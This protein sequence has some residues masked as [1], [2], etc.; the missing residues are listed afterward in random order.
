MTAAGAGP[1]RPA[2][3]KKI[4]PRATEP[5]TPSPSWGNGFGRPARASAKGTSAASPATCVCAAACTRSAVLSLEPCPENGNRAV[6]S[7]DPSPENGNPVSPAFHSEQDVSHQSH[8]RD[9][10]GVG[11]RGAAAWATMPVSGAASSVTTSGCEG[12]GV[13]DGRLG[14][15]GEDENVVLARVVTS[16]CKPSGGLEHLQALAAFGGKA[17]ERGEGPDAAETARGLRRLEELD[18]A[19]LLGRH[20]AAGRS[21]PPG[22]RRVLSGSGARKGHPGW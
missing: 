2:G 12:V 7:P 17:V 8:H 10:R 3:R 19:V 13:G 4:P 11:R 20:E 22:R 9:E 6:L 21:T 15:D 5:S 18:R 1:D 16:T 14:E